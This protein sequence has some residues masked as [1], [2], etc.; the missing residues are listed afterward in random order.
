MVKSTVSAA[1]ATSGAEETPYRA[2][3]QRAVAGPRVEDEE[4]AIDWITRMERKAEQS[5]LAAESDF[6]TDIE[7][8]G[9]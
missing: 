1:L 8:H 5:A 3:Y 6:R 4:P 9:S 7:K 2:I